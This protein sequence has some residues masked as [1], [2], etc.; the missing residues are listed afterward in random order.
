MRPNVCLGA[1]ADRRLGRGHARDRHA[2]GRAAH[3]VEPGHVEEVDRL[4]VAAVLAADAQLQVRLLLAARPTRRAARASRRR[5]CRSSRTGCGR[6]SSRP[7][8]WRRNLP[9][10]SSRENPSAVWVRSFV[11]NEKKSAT[12]AIRSA[13]KHARGSSIIV[14]TARSIVAVVLRRDGLLDELAHELELL[15]VGD[16]RDHDLDLRC[17]TGARLHGDGGPRDRAH[18][19]LV[20]L[21]V[22]DREAA[23]ARAEHRVGLGEVMDRSRACARAARGRRFAR[24]A[25]ARPPA[26]PRPRAEGTRAA[27]GRAAG[28]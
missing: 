10:T 28:S 19:H 17:G 23:A 26:R 8:T 25:P 9:S 27:A 11:P 20:D 7:G 4:G 15:L 1:V 24:C 21:R 13:T 3:V 16:E 18:L 2:V 22:H 5:A 6:R 14:P 12:S